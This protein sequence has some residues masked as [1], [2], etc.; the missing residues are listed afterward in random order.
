VFTLVSRFVTPLRAAMVGAALVASAAVALPAAPAMARAAPDSFADLAERLQPSVVNISTVQQVEVGRG[1]RFPPGSPLEELFRQFE[2]Q[3]RGQQ[4]PRGQDRDQDN[5]GPQEQ[6]QPITREARS[7]G[8]GFIIDASGFV[9]TNNHVITAQ[10]GNRVVDKVQVILQDGRKLDARIIGRDPASDLA[11]LKVESK[12]PL[13]A[14]PFGDSTQMRV[15]DW[16]MAIGNPF[17]LGGSVT[18]GIVSALHRDIGAGQ[19]DNFIQ[20]DASINRG[21]S[22]GPMFNMAGEVIG[23]NTAIYSPTGGNVGIGFAIPSAQARNIIDQL[24]TAGKVRRGWLGVRIQSVT[25]DIAESLGLGDAGGAIVS[26]VEPGAPAFRAGVKSGDVIRKFDG[27]ALG[28]NRSLPTVVSETPIG[29]TVDMEVLRGGKPVTLRVTVGEM[30]DFNAVAS[31]DRDEPKPNQPKQDDGASKQARQSLGLSL[32]PLDADVRRQLEV[33]TDVN[34]VVISSVNPASDA[35]AKGVQRGDIITD[36]NQI[37]VK[38]P[39]EAAKVLDDVRKANR[40]TVLL[41]LR[42]GAD[43]IHIPVRLMSPTPAPPAK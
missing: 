40:T 38:S 27:K 28:Q 16:V 34:G 9:V 43:F 22:G 12:T 26:S 1:M 32:Q 29:R 21:N 2:R 30:P 15:G 6:N 5:D 10:D 7:L 20:T 25:D 17:G 13:P 23:I 8:S 37:G 42:R 35:A 39:A 19:Y 31:N 11:L 18:A 3:Q 24:R 41:R 33:P 4:A 36:I 14:V